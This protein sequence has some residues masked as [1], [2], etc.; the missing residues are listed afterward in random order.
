MLTNTSD[1][2]IQHKQV[3]VVVAVTTCSTRNKCLVSWF[4]IQAQL[5][6]NLFVQFT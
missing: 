2:F 5:A 1:V 4:P 3:Y 6:N